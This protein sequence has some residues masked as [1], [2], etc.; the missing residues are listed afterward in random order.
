M[1]DKISSIVG[2][3]I[4]VF[5]MSL[6]TA[7]V[8]IGLLDTVATAMLYCLAID[9][10]LNGGVPAKGPKT[11]HDSID[12]VKSDSEAKVDDVEKAEYEAPNTN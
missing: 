6:L 11:F 7:S 8:F 9:M 4:V 3:M 1:E 2:P 12:K 5:L 10:D